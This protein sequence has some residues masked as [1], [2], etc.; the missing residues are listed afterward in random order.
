MIRTLA[1][2]SIGQIDDVTVSL[3]EGQW[4]GLTGFSGKAAQLVAE[5][6]NGTR[7]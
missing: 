5:S 1:L 4:G 7:R 2:R 6:V 3:G